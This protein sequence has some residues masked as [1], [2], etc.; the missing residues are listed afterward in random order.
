MQTNEQDFDQLAREAQ[1]G[2]L[3]AAEDLVRALHNPLFALLHLRGIPEKDIEDIAQT[4]MLHMYR[5]LSNYDPARPFM[6]WFRTIARNLTVNYWQK[7]ARDKNKFSEFQE[8]VVASEQDLEKH[9][10]ALETRQG[11]LSRCI[12]KLKSKQQA[13]I[14]LYYVDQCDSR[15]IAG[16]TG[17]DAAAV[18]KAMQRIR[19]ALRECMDRHARQLASA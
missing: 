14:K 3:K 13:L 18:R 2:D 17:A 10:E 11:Q 5:N 8:Y 19:S 6:P 15:D 1:S 9:C 12:G 7:N 16:K 4:I